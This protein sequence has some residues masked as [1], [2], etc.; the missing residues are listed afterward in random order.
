MPYSVVFT[1]E[2]QDQLL[3]LYRYIAADASPEIADRFTQGIVDFCEGIANF[4]ER[5]VRRDDIRPGL[6]VTNYRGRVVIAYAVEKDVVSIIGAFY[7]GRDFESLLRVD[8][9]S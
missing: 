4:P 8:D 9:D 1:P 7:G 5:A 6:Y 3:D 2:A